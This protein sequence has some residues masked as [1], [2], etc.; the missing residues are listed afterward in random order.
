MILPALLVNF[1]VTCVFLL[2]SGCSSEFCV[3]VV[4]WCVLAVV[5]YLERILFFLHLKDS[6]AGYNNLIGLF[7][8][9]FNTL[10][11]SLH[12]FLACRISAEKC[13][14]NIIY[15]LLYGTWCFPITI[16]VFSP[17]TFDTLISLGE[18]LF[19]LIFF[20]VL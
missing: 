13:D 7:F 17:L 14:I 2:T 8:F 16:L 19:W 9:S 4:W 20:R 12:C 6:F 1:M 11:A 3:K 18:G 5:A 15:F 10:K